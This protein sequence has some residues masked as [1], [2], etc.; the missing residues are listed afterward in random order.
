MKKFFIFVVHYILF[1]HNVS[2]YTGEQRT[3]QETCPAGMFCTANGKY[4]VVQTKVGTKW[5]ADVRY[6]IHPHQ[7]GPAELVVPGWGQWTDAR[8]CDERTSN[9][10]SS[11]AYYASDYDE[12][13]VSSF[14]F[15][16]V[17]NDNVMYVPCNADYIQ[18][19]FSCPGTYPSSEVGASSVF[20]C[21]RVV[22]NK[23]REYYTVPKNTK[24]NY[25]GEYNT[26]EINTM[27]VNLQ[28]AL[29]QA[30]TAASNLQ[31]V[32]KKSNKRILSYVSKNKQI[33][34][35]TSIKTEIDI[36]KEKINSVTAEINDEDKTNAEVN[37]ATAETNYEDKTEVSTVKN[38]P[39]KKVFESS[40]STKA[41]EWSNFDTANLFTTSISAKSAQP[42]K[43]RAAI[44][45]QSRVIPN[46]TKRSPSKSTNVHRPTS[47]KNISRSAASISPRHA[48]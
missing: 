28:S 47:G 30:Q 44:N 37:S 31:N 19:V 16:T 45:R 48:K 24:S 36:I 6:T 29:D 9:D 34:A 5:Y 22:S 20:E 38:D 35:D 11:C 21:Y 12:V 15:Y 10:S 40:V 8:L 17:K 41:F 2:A 18:G 13:W 7:M 23:E 33:Q 3:I 4:T 1:V 32:L 26:D 43:T 39:I 46:D 42:V 14:G 25:D 27:L